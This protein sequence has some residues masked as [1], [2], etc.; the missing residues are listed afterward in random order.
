M[1][2]KGKWRDEG[3]VSEQAW[4]LATA[5]SQA[6]QL[7]RNGQLQVS[8]WAPAPCKQLP[9]LAM[10]NVVAPRS[11]RHQELQSHKE[12]AT[13]LAQGASRSGLPE[14]LQVFSPSLFLITHNVA[15]KECVSALLV[16][17]P[18]QPRHLVGPEFLS[19]V[20]EE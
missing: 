12:G 3:C 7:W 14:G 9:R 2:A 13:A 20:Q 17:E 5:H 18:L 8:A 19:C 16:L 6:H 4:D 1:P 15:S 11:L 10:G